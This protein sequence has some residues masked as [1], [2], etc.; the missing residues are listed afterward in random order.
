MELRTPFLN[1]DIINFS[2]N[3]EDSYKVKSFTDKKYNKYLLKKVLEKYLPNE[4]I[5]NKKM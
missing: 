1:K 2:C 5:Y 3:L 4:L